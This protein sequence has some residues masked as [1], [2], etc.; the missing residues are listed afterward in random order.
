MSTGKGAC[1]RATAAGWIVFC[2]GSRL[3]YLR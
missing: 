1:A 3:R 2:L